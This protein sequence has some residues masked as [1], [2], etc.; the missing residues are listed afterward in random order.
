MR[1]LDGTVQSSKSYS[2]EIGETTSKLIPNKDIIK[3][4]Q[5]NKRRKRGILVVQ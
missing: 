2:S 1:D 3:A 5:K 4:I